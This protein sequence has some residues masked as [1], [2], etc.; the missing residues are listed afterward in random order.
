MRI[1]GRALVLT[2]ILVVAYVLTLAVLVI[3]PYLH[4]IAVTVGWIVL[5]LLGWYLIARRKAVAQPSKPL[6]TRAGTFLLIVVIAFTIVWLI[7]VFLLRTFTIPSS[8]MLPTIAV[9]DYILVSKRYAAPERGD[10][11]VFNY[12]GDANVPHVHRLIGMPGDR[13]QMING[14]LHIN[15]IPVKREQ[16]EDFVFE[17]KPVKQWSETLPNGVTHRTIDATEKSFYDDTP[18]Y[19][20]PDGHY[21]MIGDNRGNAS[22]SRVKSR[23]VP[24]ENLI[25]RVIFCVRGPC[26]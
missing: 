25:G 15:E 1:V 10:L 6:I 11:A 4:P 13:I 8:S 22:D 2:V 5:L 20:V 21:F 3:A 19:A 17:G 16:V 24:R 23:T 9:G 7:P 12:P 18:V 14:H 26:R